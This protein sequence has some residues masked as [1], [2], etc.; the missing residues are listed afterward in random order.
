M[1]KAIALSLALLSTPALADAPPT[2]AL[3]VVLLEQCKHLTGAV[4]TLTSG[5]VV[6]VSVTQFVTKEAAD[7]LLAAIKSAK[8]RYQV[9]V[10]CPNE[11]SI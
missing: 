4:F 6:G 1:I 5:R 11:V 9:I 7:A 8:T 3:S 10:P 2:A